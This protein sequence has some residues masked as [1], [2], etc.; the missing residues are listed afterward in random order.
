MTSE[1][2]KQEIYLFK[3]EPLQNF[4]TTVNAMSYKFAWTRR[5][6]KSDGGFSSPEVKKAMHIYR[7][8][9]MR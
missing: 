8:D 7:N 1:N 3:A 5:S 6:T 9:C 4:K 2:T